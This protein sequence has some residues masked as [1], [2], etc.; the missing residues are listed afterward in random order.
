MHF[1]L[2]NKIMKTIEVTDEAAKLIQMYR[3]EEILGIKSSV[4]DAMTIANDFAIYHSGE[5]EDTYAPINQL[6]NY[7]ELITALSI[8]QDK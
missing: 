7:N 1:E 5:G 2:T 6:A 3:T 8:E 4:C